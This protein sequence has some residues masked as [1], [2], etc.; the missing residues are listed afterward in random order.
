MLADVIR[1][2]TGLHW[3][4]KGRIPILWN[5]FSA[6]LFAPLDAI[7]RSLAPSWKMI[8]RRS[9]GLLFGLLESSSCPT[10]KCIGE[11][12]AQFFWLT[13][14]SFILLAH[15]EHC[16]LFWPLEPNS[17]CT[18]FLIITTISLFIFLHSLLK[19]SQN[20]NQMEHFVNVILYD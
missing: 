6:L 12:R 15:W 3:L 18:R 14:G 4:G 13:S 19:I 9:D 20:P 7:Y 5:P 10:F 2:G 17:L 16:V 1:F 11:L 8:E